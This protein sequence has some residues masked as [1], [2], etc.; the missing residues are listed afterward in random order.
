M[1]EQIGTSERVD[2]SDVKSRLREKDAQMI[3]QNERA[4]VEA[5]VVGAAEAIVFK[6]K[7]D[8]EDSEDAGDDLQEDDED[9]VSAHDMLSFALGGGVTPPKPAS[10]AAAAKPVVASPA[11]APKA[12]S[13]QLPV[14][15][16]CKS[17][18]FEF[19]ERARQCAGKPLDAWKA[20]VDLPDLP[21][22]K[23]MA[24]INWESLDAK[25]KA[26]EDLNWN[27][28]VMQSLLVGTSDLKAYEDSKKALVEA[29][30]LVYG[31]MQ[32]EALKLSKRVGVPKQ[33]WDMLMP[34][35]EVAHE[36]TTVLSMLSKSGGKGRHSIDVDRLVDQV[37]KLNHAI[38]QESGGSAPLA[39]FGETI[40]LRCEDMARTSNYKDLFA[41]LDT[42]GGE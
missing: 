40:A 24:S 3:S 15:S 17:F 33:V 31:E 8:S 4:K 26:A 23:T 16:P 37:E 32:R 25:W 2:V 21:V 34:R 41:A 18:D 14:G 39:L 12:A 11:P 1:K 38:E 36:F 6:S 29:Y 7:T 27:N 13:K 42:S 35:K 20:A 10:K 9:D 30:Q 19:R 5:A 22:V 28:K